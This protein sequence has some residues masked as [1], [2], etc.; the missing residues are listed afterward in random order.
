MYNDTMFDIN[1]ELNENNFLLLLLDEDNNDILYNC[2]KYHA[3]EHCKI[4][5]ICISKPYR[6]VTAEI[7]KKGIDQ[8]KLFF[9]DTLSSH[10]GKQKNNSSCIFVSGPDKTDEII[11]AIRKSVQNKE[12]N[13]IILDSASSLLKYYEESDIL[14]FTHKI[15]TNIGQEDVKRIFT[16]ILNDNV[17]YN[18]RKELL[19]DLEMFAD[20]KLNICER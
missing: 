2:I 5:Y 8:S 3:N 1:R 11:N 13:V 14:R 4:C 20:K 7:T 17:P 9:I 19:S 12:C 15:M 6:Y 16:I 18:E 10:Y